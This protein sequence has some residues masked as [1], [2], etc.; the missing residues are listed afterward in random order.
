MKF[1]SNKSFV[2]FILFVVIALF[3]GIGLTLNPRELPSPFIGKPAPK[4]ELPNLMVDDSTMSNENL[5]DQVWLFNVWASWCAACR[6]E[7]PLLNKLSSM[8]LVPIVGLNYKDEDRDAKQ[9]LIQ[10]GN[11]YQYIVTDQLGQTGIEYGVYGV[12]ETFVIDKKGIIRLKHVGPLT[13]SVIK[14]T[15]LPLVK[16]LQADSS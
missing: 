12:P 2:P 6:D 15:L 3:L 11:P 5:I 8:N 1:I 13:E 10:L 7:H 14:S 4:F 16:E 9:W